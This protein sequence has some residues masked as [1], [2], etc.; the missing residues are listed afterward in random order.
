[1]ILLN[2]VG[3]DKGNQNFIANIQK[4]QQNPKD[5][6]FISLVSKAAFGYNLIKFHD[7]NSN[8]I[9]FYFTQENSK[10]Q[11]KVVNQN[12]PHENNLVTSL[13]IHRVWA[14]DQISHSYGFNSTVLISM[15]KSEMIWITL[16]S[17]Y[18]SVFEE[19][20]S[21]NETFPFQIQNAT[22]DYFWDWHPRPNEIIFYHP[23]IFGILM[24]FYLI[25]LVLCIIFR[26]HH[27]LKSRGFIPIMSL[28]AFIL[29]MIGQVYRFGSLQFNSKYGKN[30]D[31]FV[32]F[33]LILSIYSLL[34]LNFMHYGIITFLRRFK[35]NF[36]KEKNQNMKIQ[37]KIFKMLSYPAA[38]LIYAS[39]GFVVL[40]IFSAVVFFINQ[41]QNN[42]PINVF[43]IIL[44]ANTTF[45]LGNLLIADFFF[46]FFSHILEV[47]KKSS[48]KEKI[49]FLYYFAKRIFVEDALYFRAQYYPFGFIYLLLAHL[50]TVRQ[51]QTMGEYWIFSIVMILTVY[52]LQVGFIMMLTIQKWL[53]KKKSPIVSDKNIIYQIISDSKMYEIFYNFAKIGN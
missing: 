21:E 14:Y 18:Y 30:I 36:I 35:L 46:M 9:S 4:S 40:E 10:I 47:I 12:T 32:Y 38:A 41:S 22:L 28:T 31:T 45:I 39:V 44:L 26:K 7:S 34:P 20:T 23:A 29:T 16:G 37:F 50:N 42:V 8:F 1:M 48:L 51:P 27:P 43:Y 52:F 49:F 11:T 2:S 6:F 17:N 13:Q 33:P 25:S 24:A 3:A 15:F 5:E 19:I 53:F